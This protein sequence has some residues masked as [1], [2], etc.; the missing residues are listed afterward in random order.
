VYCV[1]GHG[2]EYKFDSGADEVVSACFASWYKCLTD[3]VIV[4][5]NTFY[6]AVSFILFIVLS[7]GEYCAGIALLTPLD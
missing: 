7:T 6:Y 4:N 5:S 1:S 2:F 3:E